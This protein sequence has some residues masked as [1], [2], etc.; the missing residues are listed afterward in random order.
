MNHP[1]RSMPAPRRATLVA[2]LGLL[3]AVLT[4]TVFMV[5]P[6]VLAV[7]MGGILA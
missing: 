5:L 1:P 4:L 2:F 7:P 3:L 6:Y